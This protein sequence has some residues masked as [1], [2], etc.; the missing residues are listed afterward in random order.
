MFRTR[1]IS[2]FLVLGAML[3]GGVVRAQENSPQPDKP[4]AADSA[5]SGN[6][7]ATTEDIFPI[8]QPKVTADTRPLAGAQAQTLGTV[9]KAYNFVLPSFSVYSQVQKGA[10]PGEQNGSDTTFQGFA[11]AR[12]AL[13]HTTAYSNTVLDYLAAG[14]FSQNSELGN[15][16]IQSL[17]FAYTFQRGRWTTMLGDNLSYTSASPLG[18]GGLGL[19][20]LGIGLGNGV[21]TGTNFLPTFIPNQSLFLNGA[22]RLSNAVIGQEEYALSHRSSITLVGSYGILKFVDAGFANGDSVSTQAGYNY[23]LSRRDEF[24]IAYQFNRFGYFDIPTALKSHGA[25][26]SYSRK[27][28]G[29]M[30]FQIN[31]GPQI[32]IFE[33][34]GTSSKTLLD[35]TLY[36]G[37]N[38]ELGRTSLNGSYNRSQTGGSG[39]FVGAETQTIS[40]GISRK[41]SRAWDASVG[42]GYSINQTF[43]QTSTNG[44]STNFDTLFASAGVSRHF[45]R[46]GSLSV[47]YSFAHESN[48]AGLCPATICTTG[49]SNMHSISIGYTWGLRPV[50]L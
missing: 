34:P 42:S 18:Y 43:A 12:I 11:G 38:Y 40:F 10:V 3:C 6:Q 31:G 21:G 8:D 7:P 44:V 33:E 47:S 14:S 41:L 2:G 17:D 22:G 39:L 35:W 46:Y 9:N 4:L 26:F 50:V 25:L 29:R 49:S 1:H 13:N 16:L 15:S 27:L 28:T 37:L 36:S 45:V 23:Q 32:Q 30:N 20:A 48:L 24:S 19:D 5:N